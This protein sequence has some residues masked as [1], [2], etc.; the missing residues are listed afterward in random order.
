MQIC[1]NPHC[2]NPLNSD[3]N[4]FC[5]SCG[6]SNF[7]SLLNSRFRVQRLL[8]SGG[9]GRTYIAQDTARFD[10]PCV[11]KQF[12]PQVRE[13]T[14]YSKAAELFQEEAKRL[15]ELGENHPQIPRLLAYFRQGSSLYL[16]QEFIVGE[17]INAEI[18]QHPFKEAQVRQL[19]TDLLPILEFI[20]SRNVIHRD[21][22]PENIIRRATDGKL[23]LID[24]GGAKQVTQ[25]S[26]GRPGTGIYTMGY[27]PNEQISGYTSPTSDIYALGVTCARLMTGCFPI[28]DSE[29]NISD[30][31]YDAFNAEWLWRERLQEEGVSL[32]QE[33]GQIIDKMLQHLARD[34]YQSAAAV[35]R[36]LNSVEYVS[37]TSQGSGE[38][39][40][41]RLSLKDQKNQEFTRFD[42]DFSFPTWKSFEFDVV[43]VDGWGRE[44]SRN[45]TKAN[46]FA[47]D[48]G[49][50]IILEMV[51][52]P[53]GRFKMGSP[54]NQGEEKEYPQHQVTVAPFLMGKVPITQ[55]IWQ[56]V[57]TLPKIDLD[58]ELQP[59][60][61][62]SANRPVE[63][64]SW[65]DA[66]EFCQRLSQ[67]TRRN[68]RLPS[69]SEWEYAARG[70]TTTP[71][72]FGE[73]I[74]LANYEG[75]SI[76]ASAPKGK[77]R[78]ETTAVDNFL[79][80]NPFGLYDIHGNVWEWC[81]DPWHENYQG[82]P[83]DGTVW[84]SWKENNH[85]LL[86]GGCWGSNP[87]DCR[88]AFR[89][90]LA[91]DFRLSIIGFRVV[92]S[93]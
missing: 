12:F 62:K 3:G 39:K 2:P 87:R 76:Y 6:Q 11:I 13:A 57:A 83:T 53:G 45:S 34:R 84:Q 82:A 70:G 65:E 7:G 24:F 20:H 72:H 4:R 66:Q 75:N 43:T 38:E 79:L 93:V 85:R 89:N 27:A 14:A 51:A 37:L 61:F 67:K 54:I 36:D 30:R 47:E 17:T 64:V 50:G 44:I 1:Q 31:L 8:A 78:Q 59:S 92:C 23:V 90:W 56:A 32:S 77:Y 58:I 52:I 29:G 16:V 71:F 9:F 86:R 48:L 5:T 60:R 68:Y 19:L 42:V 49:Q 63:N 21:I 15:Y 26:M 91:G 41:E 80:A 28:Q 35:L 74:D 73:T 69:E 33:L 40:V 81:A 25:T 22:K 10:E 46:F 18:Q 88:S 55:A